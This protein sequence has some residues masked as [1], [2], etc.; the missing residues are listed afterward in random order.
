MT[1]SAKEAAYAAIVRR[2]RDAF[3]AKDLD[4]LMADLADE[5]RFFRITPEGAVCEAGSKAEAR[6]RLAQFFKMAPYLGSRV[7]RTMV[8]GN[9]IVAEEQDTFRM[10]DGGDKTTTTLGVY[11]FRDG[12]MV[13]AFSF[14]VAG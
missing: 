8:V 10:P 11:E 5:Y 14:P 1:E 9:Y 3:S 7:D 13:R 2:Q 12:K 4:G 6:A